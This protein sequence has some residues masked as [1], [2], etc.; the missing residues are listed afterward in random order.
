MTNKQKKE[1]NRIL[2]A[3]FLFVLLSVAEHA[4]FLP[5]VFGV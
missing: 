2:L 3:A 4:G 1:R 5:M